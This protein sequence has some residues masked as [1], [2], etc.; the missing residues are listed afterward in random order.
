LTVLD[1][2]SDTLCPNEPQ[3]KEIGETIS[4]YR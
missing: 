1:N 2:N 3:G 4:L